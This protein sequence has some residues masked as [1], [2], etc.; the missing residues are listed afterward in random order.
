ML[1]KPNIYDQHASAFR[2]VSAF[3]V[4]DDQGERVATVALKFPKKGEGRLCAFVHILGLQMIKGWASGYGYDKRSAAVE[5]AVSR[6]KISVE[7][8]DP[9]LARNITAFRLAAAAMGSRDWVNTLE[10]QGFRVLQAV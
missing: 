2:S 7:G 3:V 1:D 9:A 10:A 6:I 5:N 8:L 4:L